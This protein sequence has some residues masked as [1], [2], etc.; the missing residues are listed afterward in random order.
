MRLTQPTI[1]SPSPLRKKPC[2]LAISA[3]PLTAS[4]LPHDNLVQPPL[5]VPVEPVLPSQVNLAALARIS[6]YQLLVRE[7]IRGAA[8]IVFA[9]RR[10]RFLVAIFWRM[11]CLEGALLSTLINLLYLFLSFLRIYDI[12]KAILRRFPLID[13]VG[14]GIVELEGWPLTQMRH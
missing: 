2:P 3:P 11:G 4:P 1:S 8:V 6:T 5:V 7:K 10:N 9:G 13:V 14:E 12:F